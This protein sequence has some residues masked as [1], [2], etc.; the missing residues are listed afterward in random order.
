MDLFDFVLLFDVFEVTDIAED[1]F[2]T[3]DVFD[4]ALNTS[5]VEP[6]CKSFLFFLS[7]LRLLRF[8][9]FLRDFLFTPFDHV[10]CTIICGELCKLSPLFDIELIDGEFVEIDAIDFGEKF[11]PFNDCCIYYLFLINIKIFKLK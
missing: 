3:V 10:S 5:F 6:N 2:D 11:P 1:A 8:L 4:V 9:C 7:P